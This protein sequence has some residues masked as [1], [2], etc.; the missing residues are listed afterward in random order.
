LACTGNSDLVLRQPACPRPVGTWIA[1]L[2]RRKQRMKAK[3]VWVVVADEA[4]ARVLQRQKARAVVEPVEELTDPASHAR[5]AEL[6]RDAHGRR[7]AGAPGQN[8]AGLTTS[9]GE[10]DRRR[11]E[12]ETFARRVAQRLTEAHNQHRFEELHIA[13]APRFLGMLRKALDPHVAA[14]VKDEIAKD[15]VHETEREIT[16]RVFG[17]AL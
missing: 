8:P 5:G 6:G 3:T 16:E 4:I 2:R 9:A 14:S 11:I 15:L 1:S 17:D 12:A 13:A 7:A 10:D